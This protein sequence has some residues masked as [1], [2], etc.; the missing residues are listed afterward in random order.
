MYTIYFNSNAFYSRG[1][2]I[3]QAIYSGLITSI[4]FVAFEFPMTFGVLFIFN[5]T[6]GF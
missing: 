4:P 2:L 5:F 1:L 6:T 3:F